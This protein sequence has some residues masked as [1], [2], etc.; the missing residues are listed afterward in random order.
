MAVP[1]KGDVMINFMD[2]VAVM[3][4]MK[5]WPDQPFPPGPAIHGHEG[6]GVDNLASASGNTMNRLA[7][8]GLAEW[9]AGEQ[10]WLLTDAAD[11]YLGALVAVPVPVLIW[12]MPG[13]QDKSNERLVALDRM[14][15][16]L[17]RI[18]ESFAENSK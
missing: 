1:R 2:R 13:V 3:V 11:V 17:E 4:H 15:G 16:R 8:H 9:H 12:A 7:A 14:V 6:H 10:R 18:S 5:L